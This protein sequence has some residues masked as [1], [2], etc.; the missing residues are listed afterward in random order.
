MCES[1]QAQGWRS[2]GG[3]PTIA[4]EIVPFARELSL[5]AVRAR[6]GET[7]HYPLVETRHRDGMLRSSIAPAAVSPELQAQAQAYAGRVLDA[8]DYVGVL[9]IELFE[10]RGSLVVNEVA[11]RVHNSGHWTIEGAET[12]QFENHL[13]A[14]VGLPLGS[15]APVGCTALVNLVGAPP[16][17]AAVLRLP[18]THLHLYG[19][20][21]RP[22]RKVGHVTTRAADAQ[23][24][25]QR[26]DD[27]RRLIPDETR[28]DHPCDR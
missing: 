7:R 11:P 5:I 24:L 22:G 3:G 6:S 28:G 16:D 4:E 17:P 9:T 25:A 1:A 14:I 19:K 10:H 27:L 21:E 20:T 2:I 12:S 26:L 8:L 18:D 23:T 13:R 15:T